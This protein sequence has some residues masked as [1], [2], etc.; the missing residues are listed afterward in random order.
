MGGCVSSKSKHAATKPKNPTE[1][2]SS[3][4]KWRRKIYSSIVRV[5]LRYRRSAR[6]RVRDDSVSEFVDIDF[7]GG[8][9]ITTDKRSDVSTNLKFHVTQLQQNHCQTN[10]NGISQ[11]EAWFDT[12]SILESDSDDDFISING[13]TQERIVLR[14]QVGLLV[15]YSK[16]D[17]PTPGTWSAVSPSVFKLRGE[18][19]FRDR[20][21]H[22]APSCS[23]YTPI[24]VDLQVCSQKIHHIAQQLDLPC[25]KPH[26]KVP[27]LLIVNIQIPTYPATMFGEHDGEGMSLVLYFRLSKDFDTEISPQCRQNIKRLVEDDMEK[28]KGFAK[29]SLVPFRERLKIL[30]GVVNPDDLQLGS[31]ERKLLHAYNEK[32]VLSRPQHIFF[33]VKETILLSYV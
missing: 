11:E 30:T 2:S 19:Y 31:A 20:K 7:D 8:P 18:N 28:I 23:P 1:N 21:K 25:V 15:P 14:P 26:D 33:R 24:G 32:P 22:P 16:G 13:G 6:N 12:F 27:S 17:K 3:G 5:P 29:E 9:T 10:E 4:K